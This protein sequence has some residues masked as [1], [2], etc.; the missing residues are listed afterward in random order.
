M[1]KLVGTVELLKKF[2]SFSSGYEYDT[3]TIRDF[4][5]HGDI[6]FI[7]FNSGWAE[8][9]ETERYDLMEYLT[10]LFNEKSDA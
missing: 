7:K 5:I 1:N 8:Q 9:D 4:E 3:I 2:M 6:I 10:F